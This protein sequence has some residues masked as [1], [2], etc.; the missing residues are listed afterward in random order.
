MKPLT[1]A[2]ICLGAIAVTIAGI[3]VFTDTFTPPEQQFT[4]ELQYYQGL[5]FNTT[6]STVNQYKTAIIIANLGYQSDDIIKIEVSRE[7]LRARAITTQGVKRQISYDANNL[8]LF[9]GEVQSDN[10]Y[11][12][13]WSPK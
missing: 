4:E 3:Y 8:V 9:T 6:V 13:W 2:L 7:E 10:W 1:I 5:N 11:I 12:Y